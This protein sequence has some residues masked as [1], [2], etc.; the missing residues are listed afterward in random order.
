MSF[1]IGQAL[2]LIALVMMLFEGLRIIDRGNVRV[3]E[4]VMVWFLLMLSLTRDVV[5]KQIER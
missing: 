2:N 4:F 3:V 5:G 1:K